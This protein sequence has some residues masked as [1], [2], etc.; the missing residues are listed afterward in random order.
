MNTPYT[1]FV[2]LASQRTGSSW[3]M[4][5]LN[6]QPRSEAFGELFLPQHQTSPGVLSNTYPRFIDWKPTGRLARRLRTFS[7]C[8][9]LYSRS[10]IVGF[11][12]MY[13]QLKVYPELLVYFKLKQIRLVHLVRRNDLDTVVS[14]QLAAS[15]G[16]FHRR[17]NGQHSDV[18]NLRL[19]PA[20]VVRRVRRLRRTK[21]TARWLI[22]IGGLCSKE[23]AYEDLVAQP[24]A[25][26]RIT[27]YL[28]MHSDASRESHLRRVRRQPLDMLIS[29][30][31]EIAAAL[32]IAGLGDLLD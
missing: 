21:Q 12:L 20:H 16:V 8:D 6:Q 32:R 28:G 19:D 14:E 17:S 13:S 9:G 1:K 4:D 29:N 23:V 22:Q 18:A 2:V 24:E 3:L 25:L 10:A 27:A 26:E 7:Y 15:T 31:A 30:Y 11:K 5:L